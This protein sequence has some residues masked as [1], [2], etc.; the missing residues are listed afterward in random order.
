MGTTETA[1]CGPTCSPWSQEHIAGG[2]SGGAGA[3]V[4]AGIV[5]IALASDGGGSIRI[6]AAC[7][8]VVGLKPSRGRISFGPDAGEPLSGWAVRF[9]VSRSVRDSAALLD[10]AARPGAGRSDAAAGAGALVPR[11][12]L[13]RPGPAADRVL[14]AAVERRAG[15]SRARRRHGGDGAACWPTSATTSSRAAP[16][17]RLGAVPAVHGRHVERQHGPRHRRVRGRAGPRAVARQPGAGH[18]RDVALR[19]GAER[20]RGAGGAR[21]HQRREPAA[22]RVLRRVGRAA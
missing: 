7:C 4:G 2:S 22:G 14:H 13:P 9:A 1:L 8:G 20:R 21:P 16:A 19:G 5:P 18:L 15:A 10:A 11:R 3:S 17:R 6:P 12:V